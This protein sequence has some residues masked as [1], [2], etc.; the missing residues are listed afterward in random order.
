VAA[1]ILTPTSGQVLLGKQD[2]SGRPSY[3]RSRQ[4]LLAAPEGPGIFARMTV[5]DN[6]RLMLPKAEDR[7]IVY[8]RFAVLA[9]RRS[10]AAG[11]LSGGE[12]K[13][14]SLAPLLANR[15]KVLIA[16]EPT[17]GLAPTMAHE[18]FSIIYDLR[19]DGAAVLIIEEKTR[20]VLQV[21]DHLVVLH[22][23]SIVWTGHPQETSPERLAAGYLGIN[24]HTSPLDEAAT[25]DASG[26]QQ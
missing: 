18:V 20:E 3:W 19:D 8:G 24:L 22:L 6:L 15:P 17:L 16:D 12:Q 21:A 2:A 26:P 7:D 13:L 10:V 25:L 23:G 9:S 1:G 14:L 11:L 4:G 5:D